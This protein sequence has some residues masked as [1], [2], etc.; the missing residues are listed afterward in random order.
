MAGELLWGVVDGPDGLDAVHIPDDR[1]DALLLKSRHLTFWCGKEAG[2]CGG[3]LILAAGPV[4]RP[5]FRHHPDARCAFIGRE[6]KAGPAYEHLRYQRAL[7]E[8]LTRQGYSPVLEKTLGSDGRTDL[9][10]VVDAVRHAIEVQL[11]PL[12]A[13][14][15][16][17]RDAR[18]RRHHDHVTWLYG[19]AAEGGG[20]TE[21]SVRGVSFALRPGPEIGVRDVDDGTHWVALADCRLTSAGFFAPGLEQAQALHN[22]RE[23]EKAEARLRAAEEEAER[24]LAAEK[25]REAAESRQA[26]ARAA[27]ERALSVGPTRAGISRDPSQCG[28]DRW[29]GL[30]PEARAWMP[31]QGWDWLDRLPEGLHRA[32]RAMAYATQVLIFASLT[33]SVIPDAFNDEE[34]EL[35]FG[36]LEDAGMVKRKPLEDGRERWERCS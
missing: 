36:A 25:A 33:T 17:E 18:Y 28:L 7:H 11:S 5:Y 22:Q 35:L 32:G 30:F 26:A 8:W 13:A 16:R 31:V 34:R 15:W 1:S 29:E 2:G 10:V 23:A 14:S 19:A 27:R 24:R 3:V 6:A 21:L 9:H 12:S 4:R 20:A